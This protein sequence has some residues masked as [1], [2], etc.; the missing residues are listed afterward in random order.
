MY[1]TIKDGEHAD[2]LLH[3]AM[4]LMYAAHSLVEEPGIVIRDDSP[5]DFLGRAIEY[6][7]KTL[8]TINNE[9][10]EREKEARA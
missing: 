10:R 9:Q 7:R 8:D 1:Y 2:K 3:E 5:E 6:T 4:R